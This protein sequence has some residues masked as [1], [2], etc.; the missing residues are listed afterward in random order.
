MRTGKRIFF[1][2]AYQ[3]V[4]IVARLR[5]MPAEEINADRVAD[6]HLRSKRVTNFGCEVVRS[7]GSRRERTI[8]A[9]I[10]HPR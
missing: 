8:R 5:K 4:K 1:G 10:R 2:T 6:H 9:R 3:V 7:N